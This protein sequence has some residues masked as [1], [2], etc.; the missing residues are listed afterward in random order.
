MTAQDPTSSTALP[1]TPATFLGLRRM[2]VIETVAFLL[3][4]LLIDAIFLGGDR[5]HD[6]NPHPFWL[7]ILVVTVQYGPAEGVMAAILSSLAL[8]LGQF[9]AQTLGED[10]H[11]W[12]L[13]ALSLPV[14]WLVAAFLLGQF[15][16]RHLAIRA[17]LR[18]ELA[19]ARTN[20]TV[21]VD[22]LLTMSARKDKLEEAIAGQ[23]ETLSLLATSAQALYQPT[24]DQVIT[25]A[26]HLVTSV[27]RPRGFSLWLAGDDGLVPVLTVGW[28]E[29]GRW[30][31]DLSPAGA[32]FR[33]IVE[34]RR[35]LAVSRHGDE[36]VLDGQGLLAGSI[37]ATGGAPI[38]MLKIEDMAFADLTPATIHRFEILCAWIAD[39]LAKTS[40]TTHRLGGAPTPLAP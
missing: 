1:D 33:A 38:G 13:H 21:L 27:L 20:Q 7:I 25:G 32:L 19:E 10:L 36:I 35:V 26:G 18:R 31:H 28:V 16:A 12:L 22:S 5:F 29:P 40:G 24:I 17:R 9:P 15:T 30:R 6:V 8:L 14:T 39:A 34:E 2:A 11:G 37:T 3:F 4:A 23:R